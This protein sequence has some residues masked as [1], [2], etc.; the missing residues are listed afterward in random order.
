MHA[1]TVFA[2]GFQRCA[3][4][5]GSQV[6]TADADIDDIRNR[7]AGKAAPFPGANAFAEAAHLCQHPPDFRHNV[8]AVQHN[9]SIGLIAQSGMQDGASL[10][11][12]DF[13]AAEHGFDLRAKLR[14]LRQVQKQAYGL[15]GNAVLGIVKED[16][17]EPDGKA[18][19]AVR[20]LREKRAHVQVFHLRIVCFQRL[21]GGCLLQVS[22]HLHLVISSGCCYHWGCRA[23]RNPK[24]RCPGRCGSSCR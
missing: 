2:V 18:L 3:D 9:G 13:L 22:A 7:F 11:I 12:V 6:R 14:V 5:L 8:R 4:H 23:S 10:G 24:A 20:F 17:F 15:I 1:Q 19:E 21:P 16:V